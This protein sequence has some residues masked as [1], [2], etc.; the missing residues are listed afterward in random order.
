M[1]I[2]TSLIT[3]AALAFSA[4]AVQAGGLSPEIMETPVVVQDEMAPA[5]SSVSSGLIILGILAL[6]IAAASSNDNGG[7]DEVITESP[8]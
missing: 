4:S 5:G 2:T 8:S 1:R 7:T 6:L 3:A